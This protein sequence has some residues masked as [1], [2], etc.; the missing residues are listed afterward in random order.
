MPIHSHPDVYVTSIYPPLPKETKQ[1]H[2]L[3]Y[4]QGTQNPGLT[5]LGSNR[6][7]FKGAS[8]RKIGDLIS[9]WDQTR[10]WDFRVFHGSSFVNAAKAQGK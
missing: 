1:K 2:A 7:H 8:W 5:A 4:P 6:H 3:F 10:A 9:R